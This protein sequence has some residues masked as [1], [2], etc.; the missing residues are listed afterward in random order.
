[1]IFSSR[2]QQF[3]MS[4]CVVSAAILFTPS[5]VA[6]SSTSVPHSRWLLEQVPGLGAI[7]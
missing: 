6:R 1:M 7:Q 2:Y 5:Q 4:K 3:E